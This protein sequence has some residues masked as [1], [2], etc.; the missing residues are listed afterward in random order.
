MKE[1]QGLTRAARAEKA[2]LTDTRKNCALSARYG[3]TLSETQMARLIEGRRQALADT[4]RI[5]FGEG[6]LP[7]LIY[8]FCDSPFVTRENWTETL[9]SL[10][11]LFYVFKNDA[12]DAFSDD[13]LVSAMA[14]AFNG[15]AQGSCDYLGD[16]T[17]GELYSIW[18][19]GEKED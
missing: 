1:N 2:A 12:E 10:Q 7:L 11:E 14:C 18:R 16:L 3:L 13:E 8:A 6:P 15:R 19:G 4:G 5:E 9:L 17:A